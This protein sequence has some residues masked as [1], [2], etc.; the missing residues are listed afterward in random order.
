MKQSDKSLAPALEHGLE[1]IE[2]IGRA[3]NPVSFTELFDTTAIP[4]ATLSRLLRVL[5]S[6]GYLEKNGR[7]YQSGIKCNILGQRTAII[8]LLML[9]GQTTI[10]AVCKAT[11]CTCLLLYWNGEFTQVFRKAAHPES[12]VMQPVDNISTD[13]IY[14]PWGWLF[15]AAD[16][17]SLTIKASNQEFMNS[18]EYQHKITY[19]HENGFTLDTA[20]PHI[21]RLGAPIKNSTGGIVGALGLGVN[22]NIKNHNKYK[23]LGKILKTKADA[24]SKKIC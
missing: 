15:L 6:T 19:Y 1:L 11:E 5:L 9:H 2:Y 14:P 10:E 17:T 24:L 12:I 23:K 13:F 3:D 8:D 21:V 18:I 16:E 4:K 22:F 7:G 20:N